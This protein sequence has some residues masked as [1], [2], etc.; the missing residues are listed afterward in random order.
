MLGKAK[1]TIHELQEA[2]LDDHIEVIAGTDG[3]EWKRIS[4]SI[5]AVSG[6]TDYYVDRVT[7]ALDQQTF[8]DYDFDI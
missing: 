5:Q 2:G 7:E 4:K 8:G 6:K 3:T 1:Q